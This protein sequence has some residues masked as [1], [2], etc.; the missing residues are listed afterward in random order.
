MRRPILQGWLSLTFSC[1]SVNDTSPSVI[2]SWVGCLVLIVY[3][4]LRY[5]DDFVRVVDTD[6]FGSI[7]RAAEDERLI[8]EWL[9]RQQ[10]ENEAVDDSN[11]QDVVDTSS[12]EE[13]GAKAVKDRDNAV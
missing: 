2:P 1:V 3:N 12:D 5:V 8:T 13:A 9:E 6:Q 4:E 10:L 11:D 7:L